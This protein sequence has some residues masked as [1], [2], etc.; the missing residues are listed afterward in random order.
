[1]TTLYRTPNVIID[2]HEWHAVVRKRYGRSSAAYFW[3]PL[4]ARPLRWEPIS[5]WKG[6]KPKGLG[7]FFAKYRLHMQAA[8]QSETQKAAALARVAGRPERIAA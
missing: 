3:R 6:R 4:S 5:A 8:L 7:T 2:S 1:M